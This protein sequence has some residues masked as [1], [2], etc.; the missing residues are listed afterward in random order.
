MSS[1]P[2][3][4][5]NQG[6]EKSEEK[7]EDKREAQSPQASEEEGEG[8]EK[9]ASAS[10]QPKA[11]RAPGRESDLKQREYRDEAGQL[12]HHTRTY[13]AQHGGDKD[14]GEKKA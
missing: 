5:E 14:K 9:S 8:E 10:E 4:R 12:H 7:G 13:M 2:K 11:S 3:K 1:G 6:E